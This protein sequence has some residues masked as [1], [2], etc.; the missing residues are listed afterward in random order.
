MK[1]ITLTFLLLAAFTTFGFAQNVTLPSGGGNQKS[2]VTQYIGSLCH[3]SIVYNS[4]DVTG[5]NGQS[6]EG[7]IWG[8]LVPYGLTDLGFGL[9]NPSPWRAGANENTII[10]F[11]HDMLVQGKPIK[12]GK[13]GLH[14]VAEEEGPWTIILSNNS[15]AW[16]SFFYKEEEDALRVEATPEDNEFHEWLT[17]EFTDRQADN[18]TVALMWENKK[19]PFKIEVPDVKQLYVDNM[20][21]E[22]ESTAGFNWQGW[23]TAANY[24][25]QNDIN[26]EEALTWA[27]NAISAPFIGNE[28]FNTL[29]TKGLVLMKLQR[30]E[31]ALATM[32][33]AIRHAT[34]NA[35]QIHQFGRQLIGLGMKEKAMEVFEYN[36]ER[37]EGAWPTSVGMMRGLSA[38]GKYKEA[39]KYAKIAHEEAPDKLNKDNLA[40]LIKN[41]EKGQG[42]N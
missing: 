28:N 6:R 36:H 35:G 13:Y 26:L 31:D 29:Q 38:M 9:R 7:Q 3:V 20:R 39:L 10:K 5:P 37:F 4:P 40:N 17:F 27:D 32:D 19:L 23:M 12:A 18:A 41:L 25:A 15:T 2:I 42:V 16:G 11:S 21:K 30:Q 14:V 8:Q 1:Q 34:A 24:C 22:L 33:K